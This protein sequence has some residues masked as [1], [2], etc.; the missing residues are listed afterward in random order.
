MGSISL[1]D[2][3]VIASFP[4]FTGLNLVIGEADRLGLVAA[5]GAGKTTLLKCLDRKSVV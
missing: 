5:N 4:L 2:V 3:S 1:R